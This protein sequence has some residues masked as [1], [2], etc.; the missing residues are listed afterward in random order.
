MDNGKV[1]TS[2]GF[3]EA[4][5]GVVCYVAFS[6]DEIFTMDNQSW[7]S[8]HYYVMH[9]WVRIPILISLDRVVERLGSDNLTK[10]IM[11][12]LIIGGGVLRDQI[13]QK[14]ICFGVDGVNVFQGANS[15]VTKQMKENYAP[16]SIKVHCMVHRTNLAVQTLLGL[17]LMIK[18][19][20]LLQTLHS[21]FAHSPK[22]HLEFT[23]LAKLM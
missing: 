7:L 12:V 15:G 16:H 2:R 19:E 23:K 6:C 3:E 4:T 11:K 18:L 8:M 21:Y 9:N 17:P 10:V 1:H 13:A 22:R 20:N 5:M 14:L